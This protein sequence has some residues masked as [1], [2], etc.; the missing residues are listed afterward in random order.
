MKAGGGSMNVEN[1]PT[2]GLTLDFFGPAVEFLTSPDDEQ[3]DFCVLKGTIPAG[4]SVPLHSHR[5]TEDFLI[6]SGSVEV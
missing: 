4:G 1:N 2:T 5:D 6:I 3:N